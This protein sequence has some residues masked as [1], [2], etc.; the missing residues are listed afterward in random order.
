[1]FRELWSKWYDDWRRKLIYAL[2]GV[3]H[4][5]FVLHLF[6]LE[7]EMLALQGLTRKLWE[8]NVKMCKALAT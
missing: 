3:P 5:V 7:D 1:M 2:G 8:A 6:E 4:D